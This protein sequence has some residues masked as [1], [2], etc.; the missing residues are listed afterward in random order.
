LTARSFDETD[1]ALVAVFQK[2]EIIAIRDDR[3]LKKLRV[4]NFSIE[5][6]TGTNCCP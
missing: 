5:A 1:Q 2:K 3:T 4:K 6:M